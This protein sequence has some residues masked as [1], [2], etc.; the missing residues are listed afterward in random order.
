M[1]YNTVEGTVGC[2]LKSLNLFEIFHPKLHLPWWSHPIFCDLDPFLTRAVPIER[3]HRKLSIDTGLVKTDL[4]RKR[5]GPIKVD[6]FS[7][8]IFQTNS[9]FSDRVL[10]SLPL[11]Y[12]EKWNMGKP[13]KTRKTIRRWIH[14][15][16]MMWK[17]QDSA[18][19]TML[20]RIWKVLASTEIVV[21]I[22]ISPDLS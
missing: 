17:S 11:Y 7:G 9:D 18:F 21:V 15:E 2:W 14:N 6:A 5:Y 22:S 20:I 10:L 12:N 1:N 16:W 3:S 13:T 4:N 19:F 8:E